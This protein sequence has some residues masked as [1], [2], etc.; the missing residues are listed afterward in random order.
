MKK[1]VL[2]ILALVVAALSLFVLA[3]CNEYE[4]GPIS[5]GDK[6]GN[7]MSNGGFAVKQGDWVI[8]LAA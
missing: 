3:A 7:V 5:G 4:W 2:I 1:K 8:P 6:S